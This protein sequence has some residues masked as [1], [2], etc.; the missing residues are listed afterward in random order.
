MNQQNKT[1]TGGDL[2]AGF[3]EEVCAALH[4][5]TVPGA[6][7]LV[8]KDGE[9]LM[10]QGFGKRHVAADLDVTPC[11]LFAIGSSGKAFTSAAIA[12]LVEEGKL[13]WETPIR[14]YLPTFT[15]Q[16]QF[17]TARMTVRDLLSHRCGLP[18]H[19]FLWYGSRGTRKETIERLAYLEPS[20]DFRTLF[21]YNN[22][23]FIA[24]GYLVECVTGQSWE[25]FV[26]ERIFT[27]LGM[28]SSTTRIEDSR[29][30]GDYALPYQE[31]GGEIVEIPFY[32]QWQITCPAGGINSNLEDIAHWLRF[33]LN[34]GRHG[35][36]QLLATEY[37]AQNH[38]PH[39]V[40]PASDPTV[41]IGM[42]SKSPEF[43]NWCYG[44]GWF[45]GTFRG[46]R[47]V[48]HG[49]TINGFKAEVV[50]LPDEK[51]AVAVFAN[52]SGT[53]TPYSIAF[54]ACD[55]LLG[56][57]RTDWNGRIQAEVAESKAQG[58]KLA[59]AE[60]AIPNTR[61]S[62]HLE[63]YCGRYEHP[64]YG[65]VTI[66]C[67]EDQLQFTYNGLSSSLTHFH[68]DIFA[69]NMERIGFKEKVSFL[70]AEKGD[71][72][73]LAVK[74]EPAVNVQVFTRVPETS[75]RLT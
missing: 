12:M 19:D 74:M 11:T 5:D 71:I 43:S 48:Q 33:Q 15:L 2:L 52:K 7:V 61:P 42:G 66:S 10:S 58:E 18:R 25:E 62:H 34:G 45:I 51:V 16:D 3:E 65:L 75:G 41:A 31:K 30:T 70:T 13:A 8:I 36:V 24:A 38:T 60:S 49:G 67:E 56:A 20:A 40:I 57:Q 46:H 29:A 26:A 22:L 53:L 35:N 1:V 27:P 32:D 23:M 64:G 59:M 17:A 4:D 28:T 69:M 72:G 21:Q 14:E 6:A 39:T 47:M 9:I 54:L 55:R 63:G 50:L 73:S 37:L 68:Y 44:Q